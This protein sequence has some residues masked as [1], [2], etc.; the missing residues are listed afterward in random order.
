MRSRLRRSALPLPAQVLAADHEI[1][2][3]ELP[4]RRLPLPM[5][6][7]SPGG[8]AFM[9]RKLGEHFPLRTRGEKARTVATTNVAA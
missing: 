4:I 1:E 8:S 7:V 3:R 5:A 6:R 2:C 9:S